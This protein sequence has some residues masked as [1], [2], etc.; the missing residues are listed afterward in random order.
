[1]RESESWQ[2]LEEHHRRTHMATQNEVEV[3]AKEVCES[4]CEMR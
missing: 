1:M 3:E 4:R 2:V